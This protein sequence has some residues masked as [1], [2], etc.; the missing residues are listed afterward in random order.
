MASHSTENIARTLEQL[1]RERGESEALI[2]PRSGSVAQKTFRQ[3]DQ[4]ANR[5]ADGLRRYGIEKGDRVL[6]MVPAGVDFISI[7]YALFK[8]GA[9]PVLIDPGLGR[10]NILNCIATA[11]PRGMIAIPL[12]HAA[13]KVFSKA[14]KSI[15]LNVT[16]G[17]RW[18]WGGATLNQ[19][20]R[21]GDA[22][23][24]SEQVAPDDPAAILFTSGSTGPSKGVLYTHRM[25]FQQ[26]ELL[27]RMFGIEQGEMDMPT[28]P[29]FALFGVALGMTC[30]IPD[31]DPT[32][33][34]EVDPE[35]IIEHI[36]KYAITNSF[37]SPALWNTVTKYCL[38]KNV[39][40]PTLKRILMAGA[41]VPG[42]LLER[43]DSILS[44]EAMIHTPYGATEAL[45]VAST[46]HRKIV[47]ETWAQTQQGKGTC[48]GQ[49]VDGL[50][51]KII[52]IT[53]EAIE[54]WDDS[55]EMPQG[56]IGE[57]VVQSPWVTREYFNRENATRL[58][59]IGDG[60]NF[61]HR[62]GDVGYLDD[63]NRLWFCGRKSHRVQTADGTLFTI[64]CEAIFN[65]HSQVKRSALVGVGPAG[66]QTPVIVIEPEG[67]INEET[68]TEEL[69]A[70]GAKHA[71]TQSIRRVLFHP[72]F[73]VDIRHNAKIG[74]EQL[75]QW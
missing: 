14:F 44:P 70:L 56:A 50:T 32:R 4:D 59:K 27:R 75:A 1:A 74:R 11:Q 30:V 46:T 63:N 49:A 66:N 53:D 23:F 35:T 3:L 36:N 55:L 8:M 7:T 58:A 37:G 29:L 40:L 33:P 60:D 72:S 24:P 62:M 65:T 13:R 34:A 48:V 54:Q 15:E 41:P 19:I 57:V 6:L 18:L 2:V 43:F 20:R 12:A 52:K 39:Q 73:P 38:Q 51:L 71:V 26:V 16:V 25:F 9:V 5:I 21:R 64:P 68:V 10:R 28:F 61:W 47:N 22:G 42:S 67:A 17:R 45:P 31:M 69:L